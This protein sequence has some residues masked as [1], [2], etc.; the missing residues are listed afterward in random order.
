MTKS[1]R[2]MLCPNNVQRTRLF[3]TA[4]AARYAYNW[5]LALQMKTLEDTG[6]YLSD[7][8]ARK[9]FTEHKRKPGNE[10]L[11]KT[12]NNATKQAVK[13]C[14]E[15]FWRFAAL[16]KKQGYTHIQKDRLLGQKQKAISLRD[17][18]CKGIQ[19]LRNGIKPDRLF[20]WIPIRCLSQIPM[21]F[22]KSSL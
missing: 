21:S 13:D 11:Y 19:S 22:L 9:L 15:A 5:A 2:V 4:N 18:I 6:R 14:C 10:W 17:M 12:S 8:E 1:V 16:K 20:T 3:N 7:A